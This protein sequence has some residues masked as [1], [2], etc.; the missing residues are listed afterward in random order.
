[1]GKA[2]KPDDAHVHIN[3]EL[4]GLHGHDHG[5]EDG[6]WWKTSKAWLTIGCAAAFGVTYVLAKLIPAS[7]PWG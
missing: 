4:E 5:V 1:M 6:P 3:D 2:S 7:Q